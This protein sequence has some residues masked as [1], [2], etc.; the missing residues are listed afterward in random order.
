VLGLLAC[1]NATRIEYANVGYRIG[2]TLLIGMLPTADN[3]MVGIA[4]GNEG[5]GRFRWQHNFADRHRHDLSITMIALAAGRQI[6]EVCCPPENYRICLAEFCS[7]VSRPSSFY[8]EESQSGRSV[9]E[10]H[11]QICDAG[12]SVGLGGEPL[13]RAVYRYNNIGPR[14][15]RRH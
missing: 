2:S 7:S 8:W 3:L 10:V 1:E 12:G 15:S 5:D 9:G 6:R 11:L 14:G 13:W 4:Y